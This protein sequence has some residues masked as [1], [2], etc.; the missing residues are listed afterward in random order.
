MDQ[1]V[2]WTA[3]QVLSEIQPS[4]D[5]ISA[6]PKIILDNRNWLHVVWTERAPPN[7][8]GYRILYVRSEDGGETW[9]FPESLAELLPGEQWAEVPSLA[10]TGDGRLHLVWVCGDVAHRCYRASDD[11]GRTWSSRERIMGEFVSRAGWDAMIADREDTLHL[12]TQL[13]VPYGMYY[14]FKPAHGAWSLPLLLVGQPEFAEG[15]F[16]QVALTGG[17]QLHAVWQKNAQLGDIVYMRITTSASPVA[18]PAVPTTTPSPQAPPVHHTPTAL[19]RSKDKDP[20]RKA[21]PPLMSGTKSEIEFSSPGLS[22]LWG[23]LPPVVLIVLMI[24]LRLR[25]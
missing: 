22:L 5:V 13:R 21:V 19:A 14:A 25:K 24:G 18:L 15:H 11:G 7:W 4:E 8:I 12:F 23:T 17:N 1:G 6:M 20:E 3:P 9:T 10:A 16:P 2:T